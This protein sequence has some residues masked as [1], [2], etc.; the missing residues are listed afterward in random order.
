ME[1]FK[2]PLPVANRLEN[3]YNILEKPDKAIGAVEQL[4]QAFGKTRIG[5]MLNRYSTMW[6]RG[7][8]AVHPGF[9]FA[10]LVSNIPLMYLEGVR[11]PKRAVESGR[12]WPDR[13]ERGGRIHQ[14]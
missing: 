11:N 12:C 3:L 10:N 5:E 1:E 2:V 6:K 13:Q 4:L 9:H 8:L 7:M 14:S